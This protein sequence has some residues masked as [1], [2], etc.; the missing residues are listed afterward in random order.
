MSSVTTDERR[1]ARDGIGTA[2]R[3]QIRLWLAIVFMALAFGA[4]LT[5]GVIAQHPR[6]A[7][8]RRDPD[9]PGPEQLRGRPTA[10]EEQ[11]QQ[12]LPSG[13]PVV[14]ADRG[15]TSGSGSGTQGAGGKGSGGSQ[16]SGSSSGTGQED[17]MA[18]EQEPRRG[19][20]RSRPLLFLGILL[21]VGVLLVGWTVPAASPRLCG[22]CHAMDDSVASAERSVHAQRIL[23][24][25]PRAA[26]PP[27]EPPLRSDVRPRGDRDGHGLGHRARG[28]RSP[29]VRRV[30]LRSDH[31]P[32]PEDRPRDGGG[33]LAPVTATSPTR[34][35]QASSR[36]PPQS[37]T[38]SRTHRVD[39]NLTVRRSRRTRARA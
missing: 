14:G 26:G 12:G 36:E 11:I 16:Q 5:I 17:A 3:T 32:E 23:P 24:G 9:E 22:T 31:E 39:A 37:P 13:H 2:L 28:S 7:G 1:A 25:L 18:N 30:S 34:R 4:G 19:R 38:G 29:V 15:S 35:S 20:R 6:V 21:A 8:R 33:L 27:R 10:H